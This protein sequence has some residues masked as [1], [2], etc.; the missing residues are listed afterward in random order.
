MKRAHKIDFARKKNGGGSNWGAGLDY[1]L[2]DCWGELDRLVEDNY[3]GRHNAELISCLF[4]RIF[5]ALE[6]AMIEMKDVAGWLKKAE[7]IKNL[8][9][10][11]KTLRDKTIFIDSVTQF[12]RETTKKGSIA[13]C[14]VSKKVVR[15]QK[16]IKGLVAWK[17]FGK[18][19]GIVRIILNEN[20]FPKFKKGEILVTDETDPN[21][22]PVMKKAKAIITDN[23]GI[24]CHAAI[25]AREMKK[26]CV[27]GTKV[28]T[29]VLKD[30]DLVEIN[31]NNGKTKI[32]E[33]K[34]KAG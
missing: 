14:A 5:S 28:A 7:T 13:P 22:L 2:K 19:S 20:D 23:G 26:P 12:L 27:V 29:K 1:L 11:S 3:Y 6:K 32:L 4:L 15:P 34:Q 25:V 9:K 30:G 33:R 21:F 16:Q 8:G 18:I 17:G 24:L 10:N 31:L